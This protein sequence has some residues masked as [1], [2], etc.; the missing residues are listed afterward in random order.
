MKRLFIHFLPVI[1]TMA[2]L[3]AV[4]AQTAND[5]P[6][7]WEAPLVIP[8]DAVVVAG[9]RAIAQGRGSDWQ[10]SLYTPVIVKYR[11]VKT[12][13]KVQLEDLLR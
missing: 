7:V 2:C 11:D 4:T 5:A 13:A 10:L 3:I 9:S 8:E 1:W 6:R 12:D